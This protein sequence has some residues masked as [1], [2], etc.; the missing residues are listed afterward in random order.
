MSDHE[1]LDDL[2]RLADSQAEEMATREP[3]AV[4]FFF[5]VF[6]GIAAFGSRIC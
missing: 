5:F 6:T 4:I 1:P 3:K 2:Q